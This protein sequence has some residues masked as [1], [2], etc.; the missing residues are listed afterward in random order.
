MLFCT[1]SGVLFK[2]ANFTTYVICRYVEGGMGSISR[3]IGNAASE[4]GATIVTNAEVFY[5][6]SVFA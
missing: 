3:A 1:L 6:K 4:A 5:P 2:Q